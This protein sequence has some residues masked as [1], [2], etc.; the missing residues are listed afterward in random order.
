MSAAA[1]AD[2]YILSSLQHC[3]HVPWRR[4]TPFNPVVNSLRCSC[5]AEAFGLVGSGYCVIGAPCIAE[6]MLSA[7]YSLVG[8]VCLGAG[9]ATAMLW[10]DAHC[11]FHTPVRVMLAH[12]RKLSCRL[13]LHHRLATS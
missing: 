12:G 3:S 4:D 8:H 11:K 1:G 9:A 13:A 6:G 2:G 7:G 5:D 10:T